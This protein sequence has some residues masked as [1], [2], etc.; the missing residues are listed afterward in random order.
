VHKLLAFLQEAAFVDRHTATV[1]V[2]LM[3]FSASERIFGSWILRLQRSPDGKFSGRQVARQ[4]DEMLYDGT[5]NGIF[6]FRM[7]FAALVM[8]G[9]HVLLSIAEV[10]RISAI[11]AKVGVCLCVLHAL[12]LIS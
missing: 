7:D 8:N 6:R 3:T 4:C 11:N 10:W 2:S 5:P 9:L 12:A 1:D